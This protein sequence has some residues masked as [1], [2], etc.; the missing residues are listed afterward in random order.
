MSGVKFDAVVIEKILKMCECAMGLRVVVR[1]G[2][3]PENLW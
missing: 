1:V 2:G 3:V